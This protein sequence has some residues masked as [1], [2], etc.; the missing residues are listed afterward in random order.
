MI[1]IAH[2]ISSVCLSVPFGLRTDGKATAVHIEYA[3]SSWQF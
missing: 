3:G 2:I 1:C